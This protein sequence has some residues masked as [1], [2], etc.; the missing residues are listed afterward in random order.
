MGTSG[1]SKRGTI[2]TWTVPINSP[3]P[4]TVR[5]ELKFRLAQTPDGKSA[6]AL[7]RKLITGGLGEVPELNA[8]AKFNP[9]R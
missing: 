9:T 3:D 6:L 1:S 2:G 8:W 4:G 7:E 5:A